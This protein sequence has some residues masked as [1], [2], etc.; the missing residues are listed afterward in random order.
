MIRSVLCLALLLAFH[1]YGFVDEELSQ[2]VSGILAGIPG[3][4]AV[5]A[6]TFSRVLKKA[7]F[8]MSS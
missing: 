2:L 5:W 4:S 3:K 1:V 6:E 8:S 7:L